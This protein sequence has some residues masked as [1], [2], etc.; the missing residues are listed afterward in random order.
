M[1]V[2]RS[3]FGLHAISPS[4]VLLVASLHPSDG[5][6]KEEPGKAQRHADEEMAGEEEG[7]EGE[8]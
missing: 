4:F 6:G 5:K 2:I 7:R 3:R 1:I 8:Y